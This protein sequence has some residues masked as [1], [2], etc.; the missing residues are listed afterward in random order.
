MLAGRRLWLPSRLARLALTGSLAKAILSLNRQ[1]SHAINKL[2][3]TITYPPYFT[4]M[5][6]C[7]TVSI[8]IHNH[9]FV[10][11]NHPLWRLCVHSGLYA[12]TVKCLTLNT[13][14]H[15]SYTTAHQHETVSAEYHSTHPIITTSSLH[16]IMLQH[17]WEATRKHWMSLNCCRSAM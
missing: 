9:T 1:H 12:S 13:L 17:C 4:A 8:H 11:S 7:S 16:Y 15:Y 6:S 3:P 14:Y 2:Y 5:L 10:S